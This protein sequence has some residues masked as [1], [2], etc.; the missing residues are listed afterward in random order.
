MGASQ[1]DLRLMIFEGD[2]NGQ[3]A[4]QGRICFE[5]QLNHPQ[6]LTTGDLDGDGDLDLFLGQYRAPYQDGSMPTP[7]HDANDGHP[8]FLLLNNG[9]GQFFD[10]TSSSGLSHNRSRRTYA[11]SFVD[12]DDDEDLDLVVTADFAG[13][14]LYRNDGEGNFVNLTKK[15]APHRHGFGMSHV[16]G[17]INGD[18]RQ[19]L[20][21]VGMSSTTARRLDRLGIVRDDFENILTD[22]SSHDLWEPIALGSTGRWFS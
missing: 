1:S 7:F 18:G 10:A 6:V 14:D 19:D 13:M 12:L 9:S 11:A 8:D 20:Y 4:K 21:F 17:D 15:W 2:A 22:A 3:F 16:F 5:E